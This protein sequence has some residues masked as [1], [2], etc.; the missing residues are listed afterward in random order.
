MKSENLMAGT[1]IH[2]YDSLAFVATDPLPRDQGQSTRL[3]EPGMMIS[4]IDPITGR[5]L[6]DVEAHPYIVDGDLVIYFESEQT[7]QAYIDTPMDHHVR[8]PDNPLEDWVAEG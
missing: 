7:R 3:H 2:N 5:D 4:S 8:L 6:G 1:T